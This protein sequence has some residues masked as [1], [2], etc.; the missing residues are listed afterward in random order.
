MKVSDALVGVSN[1]FLDTSPVIYFVEGDPRYLD[2]VKNIFAH[3]DSGALM[4]VTSPV[5]LAECMVLPYRTTRTSLQQDFTRQIV[6]G[7]NTIFV[8][9]DEQVAQRAAERRVRYNIGL[10]DALQL[11]VALVAD[12]DVFVTNDAVL[13]RVT[14]TEIMVMDDLEP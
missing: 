9:I 4:A 5:T 7:N 12:C 14:E 11:G 2:V 8:A 1:I 10:L 6:S 3:I 13:K